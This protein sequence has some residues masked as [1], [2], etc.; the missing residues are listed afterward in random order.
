MSFRRDKKEFFMR[1]ELAGTYTDLDQGAV[2]V[3]AR[4]EGGGIIEYELFKDDLVLEIK[5]MDRHGTS[6][7][8][9]AMLRPVVSSVVRL[10]GLLPSNSYVIYLAALNCYSGLSTEGLISLAKSATPEQIERFLSEKI[11]PTRHLSVVEHIP[12]AFLIDGISRVCS[13]QLV[14]H[15][16]FSFSQASQRYIDFAKIK[17]DEEQMVFPFIIPPKIRANPGFVMTYVSAIRETLSGYYTLRSGGIFPED[18]RFLFPNATATRLVMSGNHRVWMEMI[19]KR[20]C[21]TAQWEID[22]VA[23][24]ITQQLLETDRVLYESVGPT[25]S[26][27]KCDQGKRSCGIKLNAPLSEFFDKGYLPHDKLVFGMR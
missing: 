13:H 4:S 9:K 10:D 8:G 27:G 17:L 12:P 14:R 22:M 1:K 5:Y 2:G 25:C 21:A 20:T 16:H 6:Q 26:K 18:A 3:K 7:N 23:T 24:K 19:P 11:L 15:R